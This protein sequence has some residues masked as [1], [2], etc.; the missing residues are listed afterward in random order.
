MFEF[1]KTSFVNVIGAIQENGYRLITFN[2]LAERPAERGK[3]CLLR[4]DVDACMEYAQE[5]A[6]IEHQLGV[7]ATFLVMLRSPLYNLLG[8]HGMRLLGSLVAFGHEIG[9]HF[10][11]GCHGPN[12][13]S[14]EDAIAFEIDVLSKLAGTQ[15]RAFS[16]HQP[17]EEV[18]DRRVKLPGIVNTY[19]PDHLKGFKY[20]SDSNRQW[21]EMDPFQLAK[22]AVDRIHILLHPMWWMCSRHSVEDC[23]DEAIVRNYVGAQEQLLS[24]ERAFGPSRQLLLRRSGGVD[25]G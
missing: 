25:D 15:V 24:T 11:A 8:R 13:T 1:S 3:L 9:L 14:L 6:Q 22:S 5:M 2:E 12:G 19:H 10:D 21:R 16:F 18:I 7:R 4:H 20:I 23:W 17:N